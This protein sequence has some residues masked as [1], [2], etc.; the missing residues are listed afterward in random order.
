MIYAVLCYHS[1]DVVCSWSKEEDAAV[2]AKLGVVQERLTK[3]G[4]LGPVA[5]L[6]PTTAATTPRKDRDPPLVTTRLAALKSTASMMA[7]NPNRAR[8]RACRSSQ[9]RCLRIASPE[10]SGRIG[11]DKMARQVRAIFLKGSH[12]HECKDRFIAGPKIWPPNGSG[13]FLKIN[14]RRTNAAILAINL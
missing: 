9:S 14:E 12:K 11:N 4:K 5:R 1:E 13:T 3:A 2:M 10:L 6:M 8:L 7:T